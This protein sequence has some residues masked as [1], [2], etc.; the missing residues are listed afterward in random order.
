MLLAMSS[1]TQKIVRGVGATLA[2]LAG[3]GLIISSFPMALFN[4]ASTPPQ[5]KTTTDFPANFQFE[6][7]STPEA[8]AQG[9]SGRT[10][11]PENYG[12][13]FV[14][15]F[16]ARHEFW[17]K[18]MLEPIDIIWLDE[19]GTIMGIEGNISP[20]TY[21]KTFS[22]QEPVRYVLETRS[23]EAQTQGWS[24]GTKIPLP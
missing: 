17:M 18:D 1:I 16:P 19:T 13:L 20:A 12:M 22:P 2:V 15:E 10:D 9:L 6:V 11:I 7:V 14:F 23:G 8:R 5:Q 24:V 3:I 21:P 4:S